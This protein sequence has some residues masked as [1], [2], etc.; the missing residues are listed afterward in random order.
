M[1]L[2]LAVNHYGTS[3][4]KHLL[5]SIFFLMFVSQMALL[6]RTAYALT[7]AKRPSLNERTGG[8]LPTP[9]MEYRDDVIVV[10]VSGVPLGKMFEE[11][12]HKTGLQA[13]IS[14]SLVNLP[15]FATLQ[16]ASLK[17][18]LTTILDGLSYVIY[19]AKSGLMVVVLSTPPKEERQHGRSKSR[20]NVT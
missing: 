18:A 8:P 10:N 3:A 6:S 9:L 13:R 11:L 4:M 5:W 16:R 7:P 19:P 1:A 12:K 15:V 14:E 20:P 17:E 2:L